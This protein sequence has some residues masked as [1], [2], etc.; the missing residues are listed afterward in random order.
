MS[1]N[2]RDRRPR[3]AVREERNTYTVYVYEVYGSLLVVHTV[4]RRYGSS[5]PL[6]ALWVSR[7]RNFYATL[8]ASRRTM[9]TI[10]VSIS[11]YRTTLCYYRCEESIDISVAFKSH[12][13]S[14][15]QIRVQ[16][17]RPKS[18]IIQDSNRLKKG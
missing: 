9:M 5:Q 3:R 12:P 14:G 4:L 7:K 2:V 13:G 11:A 8:V 15:L 18:S 1:A 10:Q 6:V 16:Y 17:D